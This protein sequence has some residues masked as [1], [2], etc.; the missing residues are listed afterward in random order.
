LIEILE[1]IR[2]LNG[3][4]AFCC[5]RPTI[6]KTFRIMGLLQTA[7]LFDTEAKAIQALGK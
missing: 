7:T 6:G 1:K 4:V 2:E 3:Q 5:V